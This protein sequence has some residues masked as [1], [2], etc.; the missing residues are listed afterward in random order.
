MN[1]QSESGSWAAP[2]KMKPNGVIW[3]LERLSNEN[4]EG[5]V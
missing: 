5:V 4:Q 2:S 1:G 3:D